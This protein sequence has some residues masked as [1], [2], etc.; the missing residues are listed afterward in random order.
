MARVRTGLERLLDSPERLATLRDARVGLLVNPTSVTAELDHAI[1]AM[2]GR[3]VEVVRLFAPEHGV[4]SQAQD[5]ETV[6]QRRDPVSGLPVVSLYQ[7]DRDSLKPPA[8]VLEDLD[9][10]VADLQDVGARYY[11][12]ATTIGLA[13]DACGEA[14]VEVWVLDRPNPIGGVCVEGNTVEP[15]MRS[16]VG[17]QPI[18]NRHGMT[19]GELARYFD[20]F[21][22]W[23][24]ELDVVQ[25][26]GWRRSMWYDETGLPWVLPSPNM[27][28]LSTAAVYPGQCLLEGTLLSEG[29]GTTRPFEFVGAPYAEARDVTER[30]RGYDLPGV[31][32]RSHA[33]RPMFQKHAGEA[34]GGVQLHVR[35]R[36]SFRAL[37]TGYAV[38]Q[39]FARL[40]PDAFEW[41]EEIYEFVDDRL[42]F[43]LLTGD[44]DV[45]H[46]LEEGVS[47]RDLVE[48][49]RK[50][51]ADF[52]EKRESCLLYRAGSDER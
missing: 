16:F 47:P 28:S 8:S 14:G 9:I 41:R 52:E 19:L 35:D 39:T 20:R 37:R 26:E 11:T 10:L 51:R 30:L 18:A 46:A 48:S 13:M 33:F 50:D 34:C 24:C 3:D 12:Y 36:R 4:R 43:D 38:V 5:M 15:E 22:G 45:R 23:E 44:P 40:H 21:G 2:V 32:F 17:S 7:E 25:M 27:P 6:E 49:H 31:G 29:R 42:A 1:D